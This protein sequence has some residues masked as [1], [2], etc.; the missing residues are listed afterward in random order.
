MKA[1]K[2]LG[3][4]FLHD[5]AVIDRILT[6]IYKHCDESIPVIEVGPGPGILTY[7]LAEKYKQFLAVDVDRDM[8]DQLSEKLP[9]TQLRHADFLHIDITELFSDQFHVVGN[10]PYNISSQ[11]IFKVLD[12]V[13]RIPVMIGMFQKE[14]AQRICSSP[15]T[16]A[17]GILSIRTQAYYNVELL[18]E[19][20][21][22]SFYPPPRVDSAVIILSRK[23]DY[24]LPCDPKI[25][26]NV[27]KM[28][29]QQR[30]KMLRNSL[31]SFMLDEVDF[32][33]KRPEQLG[34]SDFINIAQI[35]QAKET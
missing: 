4:H 3:Q 14:V 8:I 16:K 21:P 1:K 26:K 32:M 18:F 9:A 31:K 7:E 22:T 23:A 29:F 15:G 25:F 12:N 28:A 11:I 5:R 2:H 24:G 34:V 17:N 6:E 19:V 20:P 33:H 13:A 30:R 10:F 27:I 35:I